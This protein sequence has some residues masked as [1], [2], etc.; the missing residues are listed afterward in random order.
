MVAELVAD[1]A[2]VD[3]AQAL[4]VEHLE[5]ADLE[6]PN[7]AQEV[8]RCQVGEVLP[9]HV[10]GVRAERGG[11]VQQD[12][13]LDDEY[14]LVDQKVTTGLCDGQLRAGAAVASRELSDLV[15]DDLVPNGGDLV[16]LGLGVDDRLVLSILLGAVECGD[17]VEETHLYLLVNCFQYGPLHYN[18]KNV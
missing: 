2:V 13:F 4:D 1:I 17:L 12:L 6:P 3:R 16:V 14:E 10:V 7:V 8:E 15:A 18:T 11:R 5:C 9:Q